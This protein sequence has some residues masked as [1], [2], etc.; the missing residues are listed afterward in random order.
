MVSKSLPISMDIPAMPVAP[1]MN[2]I[3]AKM[4]NAIAARNI[5]TSLSIPQYLA[6]RQDHMQ[7]V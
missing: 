5:K 6:D 3:I 7:T 2:A 4:K 1:K